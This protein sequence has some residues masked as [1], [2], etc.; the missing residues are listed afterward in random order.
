MIKLYTNIAY[1]YLTKSSAFNPTG[2]LTQ[3]IYNTIMA[4]GQMTYQAP[5]KESLEVEA[6]SKIVENKIFER[7]YK[8]GMP[9]LSFSDFSEVLSEAGYVIDEDVTTSGKS[10]A[11][12]ICSTYASGQMDTACL[13]N[14]VPVPNPTGG[15]GGTGG[16]GAT[17]ATGATGGEEE[18][19]TREDWKGLDT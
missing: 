8:T 10:I 9:V 2:D 13:N 3:D 1:A 12:C 16:T 11:D 17:G 4:G 14:I 18:I 6:D 19:P 15:T 7:E 5:A